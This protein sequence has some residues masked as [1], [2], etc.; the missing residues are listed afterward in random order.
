MGSS[1]P[2]LTEKERSGPGLVSR[3]PSLLGVDLVAWSART[4]RSSAGHGR[5]PMP[6]ADQR[7]LDLQALRRCRARPGCSPTAHRDDASGQPASSFV[8]S[9]ARRRDVVLAMT[10]ANFQTFPLH[11]GVRSLAA[12][13]LFVLRLRLYVARGRL[14]R[15]IAAGCPCELSPALALRARQLIDPR[16]R[17]RLARSLRGVVQYVDRAVG[18]PVLVS[19]VVIDRAAVS[20]DRETILGLAERLEGVDPVNPRGIV[21]AQKLLTDGIDS[22]LFNRCCARTIAEAVWEIAD[23]LG[24][25]PPIA[26]FDA[27]VR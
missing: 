23:A 16:T 5:T 11:R 10:E 25:D 19:A 9:T 27:V 8:S 21:L 22:P 12:R 4:H 24:A 17:Q 2:G 26:G 14:D 13:G 3:P 20:A 6:Q 7:H 18:R 1:R 15:Q